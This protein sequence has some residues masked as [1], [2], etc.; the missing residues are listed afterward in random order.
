MSVGGRIIEKLPMALTDREHP[1]LRKDVV[2]YWVLDTSGGVHDEVCVYADPAAVEPQLGDA[3]WWQGG[4]IFFNNDESWLRK[5]GFSF[6][7]PAPL[8]RSQ[9]DG[10]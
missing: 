5:V 1:A 3:I 10:E 2:R 7:P 8:V 4:R 9:E 6:Q